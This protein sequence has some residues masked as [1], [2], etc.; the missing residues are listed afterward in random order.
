MQLKKYID[1]MIEYVIDES[2][3]Y[4]FMTHED[5]VSEAQEILKEIGFKIIDIEHEDGLQYPEFPKYLDI[6][7]MLKPPS[8]KICVTIDIFEF[9]ELTPE[10]K[11]V[12]EIPKEHKLKFLEILD[13]VK[14]FDATYNET[15]VLFIHEYSG[16]KII[17]KKRSWI[18]DGAHLIHI[19]D[20]GY[21]YK[22]HD[23][24]LVMKCFGDHPDITTNDVWFGNSNGSTNM[25]DKEYK[26]LSYQLHFMGK[27]LLSWLF[28]PIH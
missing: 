21:S 17:T 28:L 1:Y 26:W 2:S 4:M 11:V 22:N 25:G 3:E 19:V 8:Y 6:K 16:E 15:K 12:D 18:G 5:D 24:D 9:P 14:W 10:I 13:H 27:K 7:Y 20:V 23:F